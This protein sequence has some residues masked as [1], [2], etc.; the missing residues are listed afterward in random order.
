MEAE[1]IWGHP[2]PTQRLRS[3]QPTR[4]LARY[5]GP[6][7]AEDKDEAEQEVPPPPLHP[8]SG[9]EVDADEVKTKLQ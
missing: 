7:G 1:K 5:G 3:R 9:N 8:P 6:D 4:R 2:P